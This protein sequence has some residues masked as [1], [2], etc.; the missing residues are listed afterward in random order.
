M[1]T[2][3]SHVLSALY[4]RT[5]ANMLV[6]II[7]YILHIIFTK[8][9][10]PNYIYRRSIPYIKRKRTHTKTRFTYNTASVSALAFV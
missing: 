8:D 3:I 5:K 7:A 10:N 2:L 1:D 4:S 9:T 6:E